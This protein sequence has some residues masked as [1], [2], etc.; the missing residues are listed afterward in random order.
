[1]KKK[2]K[3]IKVVSILYNREQIMLDERQITE[4]SQKYLKGLV[5]LSKMKEEGARPHI[6]LKHLSEFFN[7]KEDVRKFIENYE[8]RNENES[9]KELS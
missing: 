1:M 3:L 8:K 6:Y 9:K 7:F 4:I 2:L 5:V